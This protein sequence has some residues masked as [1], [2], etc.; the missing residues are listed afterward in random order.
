MFGW[1]VS[2]VTKR[3]IILN[4]YS[5]AVCSMNI[6]ACFM[7][8]YGS[9]VLCY[10]LLHV[11]LWDERD[12]QCCSILPAPPPHQGIELSTNICKVHDAF[13]VS[14]GLLWA[15]WNFAKVCW[16]LHQELQRIWNQV[17]LPP[18]PRPDPGCSQP[19][20]GATTIWTRAT[21]PQP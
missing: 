14:R 21:Q 19:Q 4:I 15:L 5:G 7:I 13:L 18:T 20:Q 11:T 16:H 12:L 1:R 6:K 10:V 17:Q 3:H 8:L 2:C 9:C